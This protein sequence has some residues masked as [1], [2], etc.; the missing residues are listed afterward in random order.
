MLAI[1]YDFLLKRIEILFELLPLT[2]FFQRGPEGSRLCKGAH[3]AA[4]EG[5]EQDADPAGRQQT[6]GPE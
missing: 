3:V 5:G 1:C 4:A 2:G 6:Q